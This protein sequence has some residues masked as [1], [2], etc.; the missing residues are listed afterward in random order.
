VVKRSTPYPQS[1]QRVLGTYNNG[2]ILALNP[3]IDV[4]AH[5]NSNQCK[6]P[7][8]FR[9]SVIDMNEVCIEEG[10]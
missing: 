2:V 9:Q 4:E 1:S 5:K 7:L 3:L 10:L 8:R 6:Y